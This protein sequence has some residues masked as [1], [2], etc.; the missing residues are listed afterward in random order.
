LKGIDGTTM[1]PGDNIIINTPGGG[2][3]GKRE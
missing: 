3:W 2:G 1:E